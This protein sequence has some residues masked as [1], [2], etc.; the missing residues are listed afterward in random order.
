MTCSQPSG[1]VHPRELW[2]NAARKSQIK[3]FDFLFIFFFLLVGNPFT[4]A[5]THKELKGTMDMFL[6]LAL[7][8]ILKE[9]T[10]KHAHL[11]ESCT[12]TL[13]LCSSIP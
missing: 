13:G 9:A 12:T 2:D 6:S 4:M 10:K 1:R 11:R 5:T 8:R 3:F 7:R